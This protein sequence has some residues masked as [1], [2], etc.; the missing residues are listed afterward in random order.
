[1]RFPV[2][3]RLQSDHAPAHRTHDRPGDDDPEDYGEHTGQTTRYE[4]GQ[5]C[6]G[7]R[8]RSVGVQLS[9]PGLDQLLQARGRVVR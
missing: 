2:R 3:Q 5:A 9:D 6:D 7:R 4:D 1:V 8:G